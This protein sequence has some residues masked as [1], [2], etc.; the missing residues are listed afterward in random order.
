LATDNHMK[1][2]VILI[3][4]GIG[5][6]ITIPILASGLDRTFSL[7]TQCFPIPDLMH[8]AYAWS[9]FF[10]STNHMWYNHTTT[11]ASPFVRFDGFRDDTTLQNITQY[12]FFGGGHTNVGVWEGEILDSTAWN[13]TK[14][15]LL[16][17]ASSTLNSTLSIRVGVFNNITG[18]VIQTF[19]VIN[20]NT[21]LI[22]DNNVHLYNFTDNYYTTS[23]ANKT[24]GFKIEGTD[25]DAG[26]GIRSYAT[27]YYKSNNIVY[28]PYPEPTSTM[29]LT[30]NDPES[31]QSVDNTYDLSVIITNA[32]TSTDTFVLIPWDSGSTLLQGSGS[33]GDNAR[34]QCFTSMGLLATGMIVAFIV[35]L[36]A[37]IY[38][39]KSKGGL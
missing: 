38:T 35:I 9:Y 27:F 11:S 14:I 31:G 22:L 34:L 19:G 5:L 4:L 39:V 25:I 15:Q 32:G 36:L 29:S 30:Q 13:I 3:G 37:V 12:R 24:V 26:N 21:D 16:L 8:N 20:P 7:Q 2:V 6:A 23:G 18:S 17:K 1:I 33:N 28:P 10:N